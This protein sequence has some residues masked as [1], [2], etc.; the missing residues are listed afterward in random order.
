MPPISKPHAAWKPKLDEKE[1]EKSWAEAAGLG[2]SHKQHQGAR[3]RFT[4]KANEAAAL[5]K[6]GVGLTKTTAPY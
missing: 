5:A 3:K 4:V 2:K 1:Q 6:N